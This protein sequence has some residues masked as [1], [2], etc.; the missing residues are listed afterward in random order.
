MTNSSKPFYIS[1]VIR[2]VWPKSSENVPPANST[3]SKMLKKNLRMN[4]KVLKPAPEKI[5][6]PE[7]IWSYWD[8][9]LIQ[10][11]LDDDHYELIYIDEF[12]I[13]HRDTK[14]YGWSF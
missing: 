10:Y 11:I 5:L 3:I 4:Y 6:K 8:A 14:M 2:E 7:Y 1:D 12:S 9:V 13:S